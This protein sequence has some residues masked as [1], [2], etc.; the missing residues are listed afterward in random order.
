MW[1]PSR[2]TA[3]SDVATNGLGAMLGAL[4]FASMS[5]FAASQLTGRMGLE[6]PLVGFLYLL[7]PLM[8]VVGLTSSVHVGHAWSALFLGAAGVVVAAA[9]WAHRLRPQI[10]VGVLCVKWFIW[11][12][13]STLPAAFISPVSVL[14]IAITLGCLLIL[15]IT[16]LSREGLEERRFEWATLKWVWPVFAL[17][18]AT[19]AMT[20]LPQSL[21]FDA[22]FGLPLAWPI[23]TQR[24]CCLNT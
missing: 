23:A 8:W 13:V 12:A 17:Y 22:V 3:V 18:L 7:T 14:A 15:R 10:S 6:L 4:V 24:C 1:L 20:P 19:L 21:E 9:I 5:R 11:F 16:A 2:V